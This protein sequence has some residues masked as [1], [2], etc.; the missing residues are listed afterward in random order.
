[1]ELREAVSSE[2]GQAIVWLRWRE[3]R[4]EVGDWSKLGDAIIDGDVTAP[5]V[6]RMYQH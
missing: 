4:P 2:G 5:T 1:M 3:A 6:T